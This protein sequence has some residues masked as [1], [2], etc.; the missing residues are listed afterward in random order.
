MKVKDVMQRFPVTVDARDELILARDLMVWRGIR[1]LPVMRDGHL[2]GVLTAR[3]VAAYQARVGAGEQ[4]GRRDPVEMAMHAPPQTAGPE[5]SITEVA[6]RMAHDKIGCLPVTQ[7]GDLI[8]ILTTT[9][10]LAAQVRRAMTPPKAWGPLARELMTREPEVV[11]PDDH[12][13]DAAA[14]MQACRIR[15]LPVVDADGKALGMLSDRDVRSAV[16]DPLRVLETEPER[17]EALRVSDAMS[18]PAITAS[19]DTPCSELARSFAQ[20]SAGAVPVTDDD[21]VV[22]GII[23]YVDVLRA[24]VPG[25]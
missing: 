24:L 14:R 8:G 11:R 20:L 21:N 7:R 15:H 25:R 6:A 18:S 4:G 5:D 19:P 3:D 23:S 13:L 10:I 22:V 2:V 1:H 12:L 9:D 16:G 17:L